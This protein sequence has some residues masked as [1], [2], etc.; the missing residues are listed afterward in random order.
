MV[1]VQ[2]TR[3]DRAYLA[4]GAELLGVTDLLERALAQ[5]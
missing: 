4:H 3:L 1:R 5:Q 2:G